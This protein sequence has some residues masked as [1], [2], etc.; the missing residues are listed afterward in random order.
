MEALEL[1]AVD[2]STSVYAGV[3]APV[4]RA[5][6]SYETRSA[7]RSS[8]RCRFRAETTTNEQL[9]TDTKLR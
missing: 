9:T 1:I 4:K 2:S 5:R 6:S 3:V 8:V 7:T